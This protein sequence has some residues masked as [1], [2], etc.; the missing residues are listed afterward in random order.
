MQNNKECQGLKPGERIL[1]TAL[2][3]MNKEREICRANNDYIGY[4]KAQ[5]AIEKIVKQLEE[6][7]GK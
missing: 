6:A 7:V 3:D 5:E 2:R 4:T 1:L